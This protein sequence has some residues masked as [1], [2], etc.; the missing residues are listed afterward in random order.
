VHGSTFRAMLERS[1]D[2][3]PVVIRRAAVQSA[4]YLAHPGA[5]HD[6]GALT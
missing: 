3:V 4:W 5:A 2:L 1:F 6:A